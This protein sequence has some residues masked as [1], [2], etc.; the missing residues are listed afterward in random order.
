L[1]RLHEDPA[2]AA[3]RYEDLRLKLTKFFTWKGTEGY[4]ADDLADETLDRIATKVGEGL[5]IESVNAYTYSVARFVWLEHLRARKEEPAGDDIPEVP[6]YPEEPEEEDERLGCL[7]SCLGEVAAG[8]QDAKLVTAYYDPSPGEKIREARKR[9]AA[10]FGITVNTL[11][12]RACRIRA[13]LE[14]CISKC[15]NKKRK[16]RN[17]FV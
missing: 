8:D 3:E 12:V 7:R 5:E 4:V 6:I 13:R 16:A 11:K 9:L 10:E 15:V 1:T 17:Q 14:S 2:S